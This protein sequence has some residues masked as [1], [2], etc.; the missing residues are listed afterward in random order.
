MKKPVIGITPLF[1]TGRDSIWMLPGYCDMIEK[2]GGIALIL[3]YSLDEDTV[4]L[5]CKTCDGFLFTGGQDV[6][7][8]LYGEEKSSLC[9]ETLEKKDELE[10]RY[11][12]H[13]VL[14]NVPALGI[15]RGIQFFNVWLGGTLYQDIESETGVNHVQKPPYDRPFHNVSVR[16]NSILHE[17]TGRKELAV[18]SYHHQAVR[19]LSD[20]LEEC[21]VSEDGITEGV[22]MPSHR[23]LLG[24]QWHP[25]LNFK[26][27]INTV[28]IVKY[29]LNKCLTEE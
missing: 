15:C 17:I 23:F 25:E 14:N 8:A 24:L 7:P 20:R 19:K 12:N 26:V 10:G 29:F 27:D 3:P 5:M 28:K 6:N 9:E 11:L 22:W 13:V 4:S 16:E 2:F 1:D 18:N 21:A